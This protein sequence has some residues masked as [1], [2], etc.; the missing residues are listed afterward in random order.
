MFCPEIKIAISFWVTILYPNLNHISF[1][2]PCC[3]AGEW[4]GL[5]RKEGGCSGRR[6]CSLST[7]WSERRRGHKT[8]RANL[9]HH[10]CSVVVCT[11]WTKPSPPSPL[12]GLRPIEAFCAVFRAE[13]E[14]DKCYHER[15]E[16][17]APGAVLNSTTDLHPVR[18][19]FHTAW[20]TC[21][22]FVLA[23]FTF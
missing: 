2:F 15:A 21:S 11:C 3:S 13:R 19:I 12:G 6:V 8:V 23:S 5:P 18:P 9:G 7:A 22:V 4:E 14:G 16:L 17:L 1:A 20:I 10:C